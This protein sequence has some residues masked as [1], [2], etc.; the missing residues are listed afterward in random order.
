MQ[1]NRRGKWS[2]IV[3]IAAAAARSAAMPAEA[4]QPAAIKPSTAARAGKAAGAKDAQSKLGER[5]VGQAR[6]MLAAFPT[7]SYSHTTKIDPQRGVCEV[8]CSGFVATVLA[9]VSPEH[10]A[11][12]PLRK[13]GRKRPLAEDFYAAFA[14]TEQGRIVGWQA[15]GQVQDARPGDVLAWWKEEHKKGENT[16][17]VMII[18]DSPVLERPGQWR[19]RILDS[20]ATPHA[21]D[22]RPKGTTG[23]GSGIIWLDTDSRGRILGYHWRSATGKLNE[24]PVAIGRA[25]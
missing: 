11:V 6:Q 23:L 8:D 21:S 9:A 7:S 25:I 5:I 19:I 12:I 24:H 13:A 4:Q 10:V 17:H 15:V 14:S 3:V 18:A 2:L 16:G 20:T 22:T 1:S